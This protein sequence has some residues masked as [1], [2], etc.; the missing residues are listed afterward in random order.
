MNKNL[1]M[2]KVDNTNY[3]KIA[4]RESFCFF[5]EKFDL[6]TE[7]ETRKRD[8]DEGQQSSPEQEA[9]WKNVLE[10]YQIIEKIGEG[11]YGKVY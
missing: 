9:C 2:K 1:K 4:K 11:T 7:L 5:L 8:D 6:K 3:T 10:K